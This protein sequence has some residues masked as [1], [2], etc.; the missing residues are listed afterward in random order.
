MPIAKA[1]NTQE[2]V[3]KLPTCPNMSVLEAVAKVKK[4]SIFLTP[5]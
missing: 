5:Q 2:S 3:N 1:I 4:V